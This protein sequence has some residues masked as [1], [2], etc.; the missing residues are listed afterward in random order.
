MDTFFT[1]T[2]L[3]LTG[4][5]ILTIRVVRIQPGH[6]YA[7]LK[8]ALDHVPL[9]D[10][11]H[12][13]LSYAWG[14]AQDQKSILVNDRRLLVGRNLWDFLKHARDLKI[15]DPSWIDA[16]CIYLGRYRTKCCR[17]LRFKPLFCEGVGFRI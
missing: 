9:T 6:Q 12:V 11:G 3:D 10:D 2:L 14:D 13:C 16:I 4:S 15:F 7:A 1:Y 5:S 17:N 8:L